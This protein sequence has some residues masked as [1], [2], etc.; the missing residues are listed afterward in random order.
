MKNTLLAGILLAATTIACQSHSESATT[1]AAP[2]GSSAASPP[3]AAKVSVPDSVQLLKPFVPLGY[4][5]Q[6]TVAGDLNRDTWPDRVVVLD[7]AAVLTDTTA[8]AVVDRITWFHRPLL[9]L[10]GEPG[11]VRYRLAARNDTV[12][13]SRGA[14]PTGSEDTFQRVA[15]KKGYFSVEGAGGSSL[16]WYK[17]TTF[18]YDPADQH[19]YLHRIGQDNTHIDS[20]DDVEHEVSTPR[21][22]G[23]VRFEDYAGAQ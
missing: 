4:R 2:S 23:R 3:A 13:D 6:Y 18:R 22:F 7:T 5:V 1:A 20:D 11:G 12:V 9:L 16:R 14:G 10:L 15:I 19:W 8:Q 21:N 17:V